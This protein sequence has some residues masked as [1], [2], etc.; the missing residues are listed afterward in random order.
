MFFQGPHHAASV[1]SSIFFWL[2]VWLF[3]VLLFQTVRWNLLELDIL[4]YIL[5]QLCNV[6]ILPNSLCVEVSAYTLQIQYRPNGQWPSEAL[7]PFFLISLYSQRRPFLI[8][9][10]PVMN[11]CKWRHWPVLLCICL[12]LLN[13]ACCYVDLSSLLCCWFFHTLILHGIWAVFSSG[14]Y[15]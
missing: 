15:K 13:V 9:V 5:P 2:D 11:S 6:H 7:G 14:C 4:V 3:L 12:L 1:C 10:Q 8:L